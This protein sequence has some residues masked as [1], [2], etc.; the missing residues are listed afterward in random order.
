MTAAEAVAIPKEV[1]DEIIRKA[2]SLFV[3]QGFDR[4]TTR[5]LS[6]A[7]NWSQPSDAIRFRRYNRGVRV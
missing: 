3:R 7:L 1:R 5:Q 2:T 6:K 4:T